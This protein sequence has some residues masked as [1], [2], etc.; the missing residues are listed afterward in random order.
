MR[1][2]AYHSAQPRSACDGVLSS[3]RLAMKP[4]HGAPKL[5]APAACRRASSR[6]NETAA[7][8]SARPGATQERTRARSSHPSTSGMGTAMASASQRRPRASASK[9]ARVSV[10]ETLAKASRPSARVTA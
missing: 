10:P 6:P 4:G 5:A 2:S 9:A 3:G 7:A 1:R 8:A